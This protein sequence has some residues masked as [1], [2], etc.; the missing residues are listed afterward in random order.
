MFW[1]MEVECQIVNR[2]LFLRTLK[3]QPDPGISP[4]LVHSV[5]PLCLHILLS[6]SVPLCS[7]LPFPNYYSF[8]LEWRGLKWI[9]FTLIYFL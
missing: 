2:R 7:S 8:T 4:W 9:Y 6:P 3:Q 5:I 1:K